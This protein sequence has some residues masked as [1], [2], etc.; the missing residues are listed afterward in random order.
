MPSSL[1]LPPPGALPSS[2]LEPVS[3]GP[4]PSSGE[5]ETT[6]WLSALEGAYDV[7]IEDRRESTWLSMK[8][9]FARTVEGRQEREVRHGGGR[10]GK[11]EVRMKD[12]TRRTGRTDQTRATLADCRCLRF[13]RSSLDPS[14]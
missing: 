6:R 3:V 10:E 7:G 14:S 13:L 12:R 4:V 9:K 11:T 5:C 1:N 8:P 2:P